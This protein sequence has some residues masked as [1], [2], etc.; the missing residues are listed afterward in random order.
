MTTETSNKS[1]NVLN[2]NELEPLAEKTMAELYFHYYQGGACDE[3][4]LRRNREA[5]QQI[6][7]LPRMLV[8]VSQRR[9]T[10]SLFGSQLDMPIL[11]APMAFQALAHKEGELAVAAAARRHNTI[12]TLSTLATY[13]LEQVAAVANHR[14]YQLYV[15]KD[16]EITRELVKRAEQAGYEAL[17]VTVDSP[18]LGRREKDIR[19]RFHLPAGLKAANLE[20]FLLGEIDKSA[21][22]SGLAA[23]IASLYDTS[24]TWQDLEWII[25]L[26][27]LP[28]LVKGIIRGDDACR[29]VDHGAAGIIVSN[30]G[31]RQLDTTIPTIAAL[32]AVRSALAARGMDNDRCPILVDGGIRRGT[33]VLKALALGASAVLL[34]RPI[35]WGLA[36]GGEEGVNAVLDLIR[37]ELDLA[38]AL[39]GCPDI[40]DLSADLL[41]QANI[42]I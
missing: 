9:L 31:G 41:A 20:N 16:R 17:V 36:L 7:L 19:N 37:H 14:W 29:A 40:N 2:L 33:D 23:Y 42:R 11:I 3:I 21:D 12:M 38:L 35:L 34:G 6:E 28:V 26:T 22:G 30:H 27:K 4:T 39:C 24:L 1:I 5:Y 25:G 15:Y 13:S 18:L 8:D 10:C 32:P